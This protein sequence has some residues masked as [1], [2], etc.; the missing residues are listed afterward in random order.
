MIWEIEL[1]AKRPLPA[2]YPHNPKTLGD[3]LKKKRIDERLT[4]GQVST[5]LGIHESQRKRWEENRSQPIGKNREKLK[6][7]L[8][9]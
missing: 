7:Y 6:L 4:C 2:D 3:Y 5:A 9:L 1:R 8:G